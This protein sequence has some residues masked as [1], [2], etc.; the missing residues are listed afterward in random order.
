MSSKGVSS[1]KDRCTE[2][3][4]AIC[5]KNGKLCN[6][7][8]T[9]QNPVLYCFNDTEKNREKIKDF[10][11]KLA[12]SRSL[13]HSPTPKTSPN[14]PNTPKVPNIQKAPD[15][16]KTK[17]TKATKATITTIL[18]FI[19]ELGKRKYKT[20]KEVID[21]IFNNDDG[22]EIAKE[23]DNNKSKQGFIYELLWDICI[24][25]NITKFT[26]ENTEHGT[27]NINIKDKSDFKNI[28]D[29]DYFEKYL[30]QGYIS[31]NSGGY[32]DIT[33]RT[34]EKKIDTQYNLNLVSVKYIDDTDIKKYDIQNLCTLIRDRENENYYNSINTL[35]FVK[36]K[37]DFKKICKSANKSSNILIKYISPNGNYENVYDLSDLEDY[38]KELIK[39][40]SDYNFLDNVDEFKEKYL[41]TYKKKFMPRFHQ[42]LFIEKISDLIDKNQKRILVGAI[43][44]SGK[45][46]IMAG[47]ILA[48]VIKHRDEGK[49]SYNNYIIITPAPNETLSQYSKAFNDY[50]DFANNDIVTIDVKDEPNK[51]ISSSDLKGKVNKHNVFLISKQRL[52]FK[53]KEDNN[54]K[55]IKYDIEKIKKNINKYFGKSKFK[56]I[57]LDE[58][59]FGMS[60]DIA[61]TIFDELDKG[62]ISYK[63][64]VTATYNKPMKRYKIDDKNII[65]WDL[66]DIKIIKNITIKNFAMVITH[67]TENAGTRFNGRKSAV[68]IDFT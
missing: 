68:N 20:A 46:F 53:D 57:F 58:A 21:N 7:N 18:D 17:A 38:Y 1:I 43:P 60:T 25:F 10:N 8:S 59:H 12:K 9:S 37:K 35:L 11:D 54:D 22:N 41:K 67:F 51:Q 30:K 47:T 2:E 34:K 6:P 61:R 33:F 32:S 36:D 28:E 15:V 50:Y 29:E 14:I 45:T 63:I 66:N 27:G 31:G 44:R 5:K 16:I 19:K 64:Y 55:D 49:K 52:G 4:K 65:K 56:L 42:E 24:K 13:Q 39:T 26:N 48:D 62:D 3:K 23:I 40:L